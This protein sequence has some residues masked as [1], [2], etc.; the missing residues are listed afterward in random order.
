LAFLQFCAIVNI[1]LAVV[2]VLPL[3]ALDGGYLVLL[4]L[5]AARG[6]KKLPEKFEEVSFLGPGLLQMQLKLSVIS[7]TMQRRQEPLWH[8]LAA[9]L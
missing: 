5:E 8:S 4:A 9:I 3:P 6:G 2:N 1:N 7:C